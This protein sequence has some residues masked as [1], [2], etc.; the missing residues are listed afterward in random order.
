M[1]KIKISGNSCGNAITSSKDFPAIFN[2]EPFAYLSQESRLMVPSSWMFAVNSFIVSGL[3]PGHQ[4]PCMDHE[5]MLPE[6]PVAPDPP[7]PAD[8]QDPCPAKGS[9]G[10]WQVMECRVKLAIEAGE[11][12]VDSPLPLHCVEGSHTL[13]CCRFNELCCSGHKSCIASD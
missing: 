7:D 1:E 12:A 5:R 6:P 8:P 3:S 9:C 13:S 2:G 10:V 4:G 11:V